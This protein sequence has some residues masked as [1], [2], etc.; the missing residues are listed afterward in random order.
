[1]GGGRVETAAKLLGGVVGA[2]FNV[3][4]LLEVAVRRLIALCWWRYF[5][6]TARWERSMLAS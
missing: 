5:E 4:G 6:L 3:R 2:P 1:M